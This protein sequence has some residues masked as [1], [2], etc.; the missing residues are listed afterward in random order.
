MRICFVAHAGSANTASWCNHFADVLGHDVHV[1]SLCDGPGL[2]AAVTQHVLPPAVSGPFSYAL[3][4][5]AVR[6][7][8]RRISPDLVVG[9]RVMS[10]GFLAAATGFHPLAIAAQGRVVSP[11]AAWIK[12]RLVDFALGR[13]DLVNSW[14]PHM[15]ERLVEVGAVPGTI[16]TCPRG[17][18]LALFRAPDGDAALAPAGR[19]ALAPSVIVTR[20]FHRAYKHDVLLRALKR[21]SET[22]ADVRAA[23]VGEGEARAELERL[24]EDLGIAGSVDFPGVLSPERLARRL[25]NSTVYVSSVQTDGVSASLLEAMASGTYPVV[26]DNA[27][28]R[29]WIE[30]G[31]NGTLVA[32]CDAAAIAR[33][34]LEALDDDELRARAAALNRRIVEERADLYGNMKTIERAYARLVESRGGGSA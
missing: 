6:E 4:V 26:V 25:R 27:A 29:L 15:T 3:A 10:Y 7:A 14:G 21:V 20:T 19:A 17:I 24:S 13:A 33:A 2:A 31:K 9:Y 1:V 28:N 18:D 32:G 8:V 22:R 12:Q 34:I 23:F 11:P 5:P 16:L 30:N